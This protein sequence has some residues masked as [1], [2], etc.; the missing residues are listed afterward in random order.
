MT[1]K[2]AAELV[3]VV[4]ALTAKFMVFC[5][6]VLERMINEVMRTASYEIVKSEDYKLKKL[7]KDAEYF[8]YDWGSHPE[9]AHNNLGDCFATLHAHKVMIYR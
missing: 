8:G 1:I 2:K 6:F 3:G 9:G 7:S 5:L 4:I